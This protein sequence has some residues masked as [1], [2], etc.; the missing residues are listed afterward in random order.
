MEEEEEEGVV[1]ADGAAG[2]A[3]PAEAE[4]EAEPEVASAVFISAAATAAAGSSRADTSSSSAAG[5]S[6][7]SAASKACEVRYMAGRVL[8]NTRKGDRRLCV[9]CVASCV[10]M[11]R[12][13][14][15]HGQDT[16]QQPRTRSRLPDTCALASKWPHA[17]SPIRPLRTRARAHTQRTPARPPTHSPRTSSCD[18]TVSGGGASSAPGAASTASSSCE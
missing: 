2:A 6:G 9:R 8:E 17:R 1:A 11:S 18:C 5:S 15:T 16:A 4:V 13:L 7:A 10:R 3:P 14:S 12:Y